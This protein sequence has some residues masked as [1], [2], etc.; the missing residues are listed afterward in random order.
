VSKQ[1]KEC[2]IESRIKFVKFDRK[3][4]RPFIKSKEDDS[5]DR[6]KYC[7]GKMKSTWEQGVKK[8]KKFNV[9]KAVVEEKGESNS[10]LDKTK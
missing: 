6:A 2:K 5:T 4:M 10:I 9:R 3:N 1:S 7:E 8:N